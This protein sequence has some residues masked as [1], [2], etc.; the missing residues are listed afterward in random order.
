LGVSGNFL[1]VSILSRQN[2]KLETSE[3]YLCN[4]FSYVF[5]LD[6]DLPQLDGFEELE[7]E[8]VMRRPVE[9]RVLRLD[10]KPANRKWGWGYLGP[11]GKPDCPLLL[12]DD[13]PSTA[14]F[15]KTK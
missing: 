10:G 13:L 6:F 15:C 8:K 3:P 2:L 9:C 5:C 4:S 11:N 1:E 12:P 7:A 14:H